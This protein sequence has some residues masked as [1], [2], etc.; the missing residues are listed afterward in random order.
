[1]SA[2]IARSVS[3]EAIQGRQRSTSSGL[4]RFAAMTVC[5]EVKASRDD[6]AIQIKGRVGPTR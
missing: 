3:D 1:V 4:L 6:D 5:L 2:V